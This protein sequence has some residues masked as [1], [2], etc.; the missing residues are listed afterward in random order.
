MMRVI[1]VYSIRYDALELK[2]RREVQINS[3]CTIERA[4]AI[5]ALW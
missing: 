2:F 3:W 5:E 4:V 1:T